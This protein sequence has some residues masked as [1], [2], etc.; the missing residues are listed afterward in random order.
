MRQ[1][2]KLINRQIERWE[3]SRLEEERW[4]EEHG[5]PKGRKG[6]FDELYPPQRPVIAIAPML[7]CGSREVCEI[8]RR[9]LDYEILG[10]S[11][12]DKVA[13]DMNVVRKLVDRMDQRKRSYT[14]ALIDGLLHGGQYV[15]QSDYVN[16][17]LS[18]LAAFMAEGRCILLGRGAPFMVKNKIGIRI[19]LIASMK[20]RVQNLLNY[21]GDSEANARARIEK[22]DRER[23][24]FAQEYFHKDLDDPHHY[25]LVLNLDRITHLTAA[26]AILRTMEVMH[27][28]RKERFR[29]A[30][31]PLNADAIL[32]RQIAKWDWENNKERR[33]FGEEEYE[34]KDENNIKR[35]PV[36][37]ISPEYCSGSRLVAAIIQ[38]QMGYE[39]FGFKLIDQ[40]AEDM[41]LSP[42]LIDRLDQR[43]KSAIQ[44]L[45]DGLIE[46]RILSRANY[47]SAL[48]KTIRALIVQ[49]GVTL[50]GRGAAQLVEEG[51]GLR[52]RMVAPFEQRLQNIQSF[53][54]IEGLPARERLENGDKNRR[55]F[56]RQYYKSDIQDMTRYDIG[57][58]NENI[59]PSAG[60][61]IILRML[62]PM[63]H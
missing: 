36:I 23:K 35:L 13:K 3:M 28:D 8:L 2:D 46:G 32:N 54:G 57:I 59:I 49:G 26:G 5:L 22:S 14:R 43:S 63:L 47:F 34:E 11:L 40:V 27:M 15:E 61:E 33:A 31:Y 18:I 24:E 56:I 17:L 50:Q 41:H 51:E 10:S 25:D 9:R 21:Y 30:T 12:I 29:K 42:R 20:T 39:I 19:R 58:N 37:A 60:A 38:R 53:Y 52:V 44:A 1:I 16:H 45:V 55:E 4:E 48:V 7:G 6:E 62:E